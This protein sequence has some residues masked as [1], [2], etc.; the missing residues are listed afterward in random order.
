M[1]T[2][3]IWVSVKLAAELSGIGKD[4]V[5]RR[6]AAGQYLS[7]KAIARGGEQYRIRLDTLDPEAQ[8][9]Y[10]IGQ[11]SALGA[12]AEED[13]VSLSDEAAEAL[14]RQF[15]DATDKLKARAEKNLAAVLAYFQKLH[16]DK[17]RMAIY[18]EIQQEHGMSRKA[19][20]G[21]LKRIEGHARRHWPALLLP[22][23]RIDNGQKAEWTPEAWNFFVAAAITPGA[24]IKTAWQ[25]TVDTG[26]GKGWMIPS[27]DTAKRDYYRLPADV[28]AYVKDGERALKALSPTQRRDYSQLALHEL[29]CLDARKIDVMVRDVD[30]SLG[31]KGR[32]LRPYVLAIQEV[33]S[34]VILGYAI[35]AT[36]DADL[37]RQAFLNA[38]KRT[39]RII[40]RKLLPDNGMENAAKEITGGAPWR[41][42][43]KVKDDEIIGLYPMLGVEIIWAEV[44]HG[45]SKPIERAFGTIK[46]RTEPRP[47]F[48][49]AYCGHKP[50]ARPE[51]WDVNKTVSLALF[52]QILSDEIDAYHRAPH[53]GQAMNRCSPMQVYTE[54]TKSA[55]TVARR[56]SEVQA[57]LCGYSAV[58]VTLNRRDHAFTI[59]GNRYWCERL[60]SLLPGP[61]YFARYDASDLTQ[62]VYLYQREKLICEVPMT[63]LTGFLDKQAAKTHA[64]ERKAYQRAVKQ[65]ARALQ[66]MQSAESPEWLGE[67]VDP[68]TGEILPVPQ[69][70]E[71]VRARA[72]ALPDKASAEAQEAAEIQRMADEMQDLGTLTS[73]HGG[74][75]V[76]GG[77]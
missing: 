9:R 66:G 62:P 7:E 48:R 63:A 23:Y 29:W 73:G 22:D 2:S 43:G 56:I 3:A 38:M 19:L 21:W 75:R 39:N 28:R 41:R 20:H 8:A 54:L 14:W 49:G 37:N 36:L 57:R 58:S 53:R 24:W 70:M 10:Y 77:N 30:G 65:Q 61:G 47:E 68:Q 50:E 25:R 5:I 76:V 35:G 40:P 44:A 27:Y 74:L 59:L 13:E 52:A 64:R 72:D 42:R 15:E 46:H 6:I 34:R 18:A 60:S 31:E 51:E 16:S 4:A 32:V 69:A 55:G 71:I 1:S 26:G 45:Q 67:W 12:I 11:G 33:R 17:G